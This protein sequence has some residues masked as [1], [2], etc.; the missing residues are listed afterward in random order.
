MLAGDRGRQPAALSYSPVCAHL[1]L[2]RVCKLLRK[3][4]VAF[5]RGLF[6]VCPLPVDVLSFET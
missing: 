4:G 1:V 3:I 2:Q 5:V 6:V